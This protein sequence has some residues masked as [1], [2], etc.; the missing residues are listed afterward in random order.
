MK[1]QKERNNNNNKR[2]RGP[3]LG[4]AREHAA[5]ISIRPKDMQQD[6]DIKALGP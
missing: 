3:R 2:R 4:Q 1:A 6:V 5:R